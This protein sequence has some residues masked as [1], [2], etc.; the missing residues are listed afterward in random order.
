MAVEMTVLSTSNAALSSLIMTVIGSLCLEV[1]REP[2]KG[3]NVFG[4]PRT[5]RDP[6][7]AFAQV[8]GSPFD[9]RRLCQTHAN[10][11]GFP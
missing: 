10:R 5:Q 4:L 8:E 3:A 9:S 6:L 7:R 2:E 1:P 11:A